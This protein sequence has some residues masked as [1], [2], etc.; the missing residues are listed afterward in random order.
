MEKLAFLTASARRRSSKRGCPEKHPAGLAAVSGTSSRTW[1][2]K[3]G[4]NK[5]AF[6]AEK[7]AVEEQT[8]GTTA[9][10]GAARSVCASLLKAGWG[11]QV[12]SS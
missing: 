3:E 8:Q 12:S 2:A 5:A 11:S 4:E 9:E 1:H 10:G 6:P 7:R